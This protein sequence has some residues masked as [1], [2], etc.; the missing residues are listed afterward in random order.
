MFGFEQILESNKNSDLPAGRSDLES[1]SDDY[2]LPIGQ[3]KT[4]E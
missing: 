1:G 4:K 2:Y 3:Q